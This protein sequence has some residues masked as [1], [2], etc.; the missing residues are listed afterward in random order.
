MAAFVPVPSFF[1]ASRHARPPLSPRQNRLNVQTRMVAR[2]ENEPD[3]QISS[4]V[5]RLY[6]TYPFPP[7]TLLD[8]A[9]IG[10]NWRWH[11]P[12]AYAFCAG[13]LPYLLNRPLRILDAGCGTGESTSYLVHLND[14]AQVTAIDLSSGALD[15]AKERMQRSLPDKVQRCTFIHKSIFD[16]ADLEGEFDHINC[17]GVI[18]HTP[19]PA[20]ALRALATKLKPGG[21]LH[22]FVY[23]AHGRWEISLMQKALRILQGNKKH[24][25]DG[26]KLG[27]QV[28][29]ALPDGNRLK[30]REK[31]RWAQ[32]NTKDATFADMYLH[33]QEVDYDVPSLFELID[34]SGLQFVGF[35][36]PRT[37]DLARLLASDE[38]LLEKAKLLP[39]RDQYRL[40]ELLDPESITHFEFFLAK[41][42]LQRTDWSDDDM[43]RNAKAC[44]SECITGWPSTVL[45]DRDYFPVMLSDEEHTF[46][47]QIVERESISVG[48]AAE[49]ANLSLDGVREMVRK[50]VIL[51]SPS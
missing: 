45:M 20:K 24:F 19:D 30:T 46:A 4:T 40:V 14:G 32:E 37:W 48:E 8:E 2:P 36:N 34:D 12:S 26:V 3:A 27:R 9:P 41:A 23:A 25:E 10:Y 1:H 11:Y 35:S 33:P 29:A 15:V 13:R 51:L 43:L 50:G 47:S 31:Q 44:L 22:I 39:E 18:H 49:R 28:F 16:V 6:D 21:I 7:E 5:E 38:E 17:V 42:P